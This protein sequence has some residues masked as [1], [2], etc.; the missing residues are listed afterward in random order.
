MQINYIYNVNDN[1]LCYDHLWQQLMGR[2]RRSCA[3]APGIQG[4][5]ERR[6]CRKEY[7]DV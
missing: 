1:K 2:K 7:S 5:L 4:A 6:C 3:A